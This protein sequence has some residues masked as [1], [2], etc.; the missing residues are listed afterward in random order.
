MTQG[1]TV[2]YREAAKAL[3]RTVILDAMR[4]LLVDRDWTDIS[5]SAL[6]Q[7]SGVSRQTLYKEFGSRA[8]LL[9]AY[10]IRLAGQIV[11]EHT[12]D[13][14]R[15]NFGNA[16]AAFED[17]FRSFFVAIASDP[18][19]GSVLA[20]REKPELVRQF[21]NSSAELITGAA[22]QLSELY[23]SSGW[24]DATSEETDVLATAVVRMSLSYL[25]MPPEPGRDPAADLA[26]VFAPYVNVR[27][28]D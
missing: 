9:S 24:I 23:R 8:E 13:A 2:P 6:A 17:G 28:R 12:G 5:L 4:D 10:A 26:K 1:A 3:R 7:H 18:L 25:F 19:V 15:R 21:G 14:M 20:D 11:A 22:A 27:R 16:E